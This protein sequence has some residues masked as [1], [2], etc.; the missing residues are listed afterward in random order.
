MPI[1]VLYEMAADDDKN[2]RFCDRHVKANQNGT[3]Q[4][5]L[6]FDPEDYIAHAIRFWKDKLRNILKTCPVRYVV[7]RVKT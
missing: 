4:P 7:F 3:F 6:T 5:H 1:F 2:R